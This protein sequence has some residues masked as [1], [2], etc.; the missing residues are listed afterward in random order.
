MDT[1]GYIFGMLSGKYLP[2]GN[3][4]IVPSISPKKSW[5]GT[6]GGV[7]LSVAVSLLFYWYY[8]ESL[9]GISASLAWYILAGVIPDGSGLCGRSDRVGAQAHLRR[10]G[11]RTLDSGHGR[12]VRR[13]R[14]FYL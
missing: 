8:A 3:H 4:K 5:E 7:L 12:R 6:I 9:N 10:Q 14:Q 1:G 11:L 2:G 13:A